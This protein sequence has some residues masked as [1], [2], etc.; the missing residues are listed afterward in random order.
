MCYIGGLFRNVGIRNG[1]TLGRDKR[2]SYHPVFRKI[3]RNG[4][5]ICVTAHKFLRGNKGIQT[6]SLFSIGR[7]C[8]RH[9]A[10]L[11]GNS[12]AGFKNIKRRCVDQLNLNGLAKQNIGVAI[13]RRDPCHVGGMKRGLENTVEELDKCL[14]S[15]V[16]TER[17]DTRGIVVSHILHANSKE[18][19]GGILR[20]ALLNGTPVIPTI[21][22]V[23]IS[24]GKHH[25]NMLNIFQHNA[26]V[27]PLNTRDPVN[28]VTCRAVYHADVTAD[29]GDAVFIIHIR[30]L[31]LYR[32]RV[33]CRYS[34]GCLSTAV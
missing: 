33:T 31:N 15:V 5:R 13:H 20:K 2:L 8:T 32:I 14:I 6:R 7:P 30:L 11:I 27:A 25:G 24:T 3:C 12:N 10:V 18:G 9:R 17:V 19:L 21:I 1:L 23:I 34:Q 28:T 4:N 22:L 29:L 16:I 26:G